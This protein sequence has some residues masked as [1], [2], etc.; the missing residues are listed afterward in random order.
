MKVLFINTVFG[1]GSTGSLVKSIGDFLEGHGDRYAVAV[2]RGHSDDSRVFRIGTDA[3]LYAHAIL[4]RVTDRAGFYSRHQTQRLLSFIRS[5]NPDV[6][7]IHSLHGYYIDIVTLFGFLK[8]EFRGRVVWTLHDCWPITG[9]CTHFT[10][11]GCEKWKTECGSC[12]QKR[13]F[14]TSYAADSSRRNFRQK[15]HLFRGVPNLTVVTVSDWLK[16]VVGSSFL[17][18]YPVVRIYNGVDL[19]QFKP[20][21][22]DIRKQYGLESKTVVLSVAD[23]FDER[24][25]LPSVL[26]LSGTAPDGWIFVII[27][28]DER[29]KGK[30][31]GNVMGLAHLKDRSELVKWYSAADVLYNP[32]EEETFGMVTVEAMACGTPAVVMDS[33]ASPELII[34][35]ECGCVVERGTPAE[36]RIKL[37]EQA[38]SKGKAREAASFF[39]VEKMCE[40]YYHL[41]GGR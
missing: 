5:Y 17:K 29:L 19:S 24:K 27:G 40:S 38:L 22:S 1:R 37:V 10:A 32:S 33:T 6:I 15:K 11:A 23:G 36:E 39:S 12:V 13:C 41:Y 26:E 25:G 14:P 7:H 4:S 30:L 18:D 35:G 31:P 2:G 8:T 34:N 16:G 28:M 9:H 20:S 21:G 3:G